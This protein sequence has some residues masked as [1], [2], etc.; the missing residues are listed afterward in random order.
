MCVS[1][2]EG[3]CVQIQSKWLAMQVEAFFSSSPA[4]ERLGGPDVALLSKWNWLFEAFISQVM[5][6]KKFSHRT[7]DG[8]GW[9]TNWAEQGAPNRF[10]IICLLAGPLYQNLFESF[11]ILGFLIISWYLIILYFGCIFIPL[12]GSLQS[13]D[14]RKWG[15][16]LL[17]VQGLNP[18]RP[19]SHDA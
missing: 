6:N 19:H 11:I 16:C 17:R 10:L 4:R 13:S 15:E 14:N 9:I 2:C 5:V 18:P 12:S 1:V 3:G 7:N 8:Q